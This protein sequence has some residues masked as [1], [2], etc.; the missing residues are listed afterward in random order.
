KCPP[1]MSAMQPRLLLTIFMSCQN[2][3]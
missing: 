3:L 2:P 1:S